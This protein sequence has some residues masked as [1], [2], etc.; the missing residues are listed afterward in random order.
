MKILIT[1]EKIINL[2]LVQTVDKFYDQYVRTYYINMSTD[3]KSAFL[4][5]ENKEER[6]AVFNCIKEFCINDEKVL[7]ISNYV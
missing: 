3:I 2:D 6:D 4:R 1:K 5:F 7:D